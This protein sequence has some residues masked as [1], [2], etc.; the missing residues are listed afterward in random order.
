MLQLQI[1][2]AVAPLSCQSH[3]DLLCALGLAARKALCQP[4]FYFPEQG[5]E[6]QPVVSP[7]ALTSSLHA[8]S[9]AWDLFRERLWAAH[10]LPLP[11]TGSPMWLLRD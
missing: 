5:A 8:A 3:W 9:S 4:S 1:L 6:E 11:V 2:V 10:Q 7:E